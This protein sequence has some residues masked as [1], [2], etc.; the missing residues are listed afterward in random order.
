MATYGMTLETYELLLQFQGGLCAICR[1]PPKKQRL[2]VDHNHKTGAIR[3][4]LC[5]V[6]NHRVL[7]RGLETAAIH[8]AAAA[9]LTL[10]PMMVLSNWRK[11]A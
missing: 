1:R 4:L 9:Y 3:G 5:F 10:T 8:E 6:C 2:A 7:G 11:V